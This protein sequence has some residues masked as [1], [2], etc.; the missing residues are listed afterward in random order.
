[1]DDNAQRAFIVFLKQHAKLKFTIVLAS[2]I[3]YTDPMQK[4]RSQGLPVSPQESAHRNGSSRRAVQ[5]GKKAAAE[6]V[7]CRLNL[8]MDFLL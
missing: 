5:I 7:S 8:S 4:N 2:C 3:Q 1:M 6:P